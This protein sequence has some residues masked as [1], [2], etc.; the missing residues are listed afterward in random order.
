MKIGYQTGS[1]GLDPARPTVVF[2]HGAGGSSWSWMG[3]LSA[4]GRKVNTLAIDLPG[5][6]ETPGRAY[7]SI[8][9][10]A[11][12]LA[13]ALGELKSELGLDGRFVLAGHSMGGAISQVLDLAHPDLTAGLILLGTGCELPVNPQLLE[14]LRTDFEKTAALVNKWCFASDNKALKEESLK[15]LMLAGSE[16]LQADFTACSRFDATRMVERIRKPTLIIVGAED[17]MTP[18]EMSEF[19]RDRVAE[20]NLEIIPGAGHM[21]MVEE[22]R[23]V[24]DLIGSFA[25][26]LF[27]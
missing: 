19:I 4:V 12:W 15:L 8:E 14:G 24:I 2:V 9:D 18:P 11:E 1:Q 27:G 3:L 16:T 26:R 20:S 10:Y 21:V 25:A 5:H 6:G 22:P 7:D 23:R 17:K 13:R